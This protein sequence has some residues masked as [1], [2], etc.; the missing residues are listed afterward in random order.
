MRI[1][2]GFQI[3]TM[4][5]LVSPLMAQKGGGGRGAAV[6]PP[7]IE[8]SVL[9]SMPVRE[10]TVFKDGHAFIFHESEMPT[11]GIGDVVID[12]LPTPV[13]GTFW[14]YSAD[15]AAKLRAVVAG[16]REI[17]L[18]RTALTTP[19][20]IAANVGAPVFV[21]DETGSYAATIVGI[22]ESAKR[23]DVPKPVDGQPAGPQ[24]SGLVLLRVQE[25]VKAVPL[26]R[27]TRITFRDDPK[28]TISDEEERKLLTMRLDW[29]GKPAARTARV[30]MYYLQ[31]GVRWIPSYRVEI[32]GAGKARVKLQATLINELVDLNDA[33]AHLVIGVPSFYFKDTIDPIA[34]QQTLAQLSQH[35][36]QSGGGLFQQQALSN[37]LM[38]QSRMRAGE[39][40][41]PS[42]EALSA[43]AELEDPEITT[44]SRS[45]DLFIF[46]VSH[47]T[48]RRGERMV[49]PVAEYELTYEDIFSLDLPFAPP[50]EVQCNASPQ[51]VAE[52]ARLLQQPKVMHRI[53]LKNSSSYPLTTAPALILREGRLLAQSLMTY[54]AAGGA[55]DLDLTAAVD[56]SVVKSEQESGR[57]PQAQKWGDTMYARFDLSGKLTLTNR[58][59]ASAR[60]EVTRYILGVADHADHGGVVAQTNLMEDTQARPGGLPH[61]WNWYNWPYWWH[62]FNGVGRVQWKF[63]L[64]PGESIDLNYAWHYFWN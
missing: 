63:E 7:P 17:K 36:A 32:D 45:E 56:I 37:A 5:L 27:I 52:L 25:G 2:L 60:I 41:G 58:R 46:T 30:G 26:D 14:A 31:R 6:A 23:P 28:L 53:R 42:S 16:T 38:S 48:L 55:T 39:Y 8:A 24:K 19:D 64:K 29:E 57:T 15:P 11:D 33:T 4:F 3:A 10:L 12:T 22:P 20:L 34:L 35:F 43:D 54:A 21:T 50:A 49:V 62:R 44:A 51:Q 1:R 40:R 13:I 47:V 61:W 59:Q 9:T 18:D